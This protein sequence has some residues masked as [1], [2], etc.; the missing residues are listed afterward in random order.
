MKVCL[1]SHA[2]P[3]SIGGIETVS[4]LL[5]DYLHS[6]GVGV[7]VVTET[8]A[9]NERAAPAY[10]VVRRPGSTALRPLAAAHDLMHCNGMS[11][12]GTL[13]AF[14]GGVPLVVTHQSYN[15]AAPHSF[16]ELRKMLVN[17]GPRRIPHAVASALGVHLADLNVCISR[18]L[19]TC[20][21]P[22]RSLVLYNPIS[23]I[24][25]PLP[26]TERRNNFAFVGRLVAD[27]GCDVLLIALAECARRGYRYGVEVYGDGPERE[28]LL[29]LA[30]QCGVSEKARFCGSV[31]GID[32]VRAY[33]RSLAVVV[34]SVWQEPLGIVALE[35]MA[36]GRAV[37]ASASG[38]LEEVVQGVGMLFPVGNSQ[39]L[40]D[41]MI[42]LAE[43]SGLRQA[44]ERTGAQ[45]ARK[46]S[47][48]VMG[49]MYLEL[50]REVL[51]Q[52]RK[53]GEMHK[54]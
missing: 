16:R 43:N 15:A 3:P 27:K 51:D 38:G 20:L 45:V 17:E 2:F 33:N 36:C 53:H 40:A 4:E 12:R 28:N 32:L 5:A 34:P 30:K 44:A 10:R 50:Y 31:R 23:P 47:I 18:F 41:C 42:R 1:Y 29:A 54:N 9:N 7:T 8:P 24:F 11:V 19:H 26:E 49:K 52:K 46:F 13:A 21:H 39:A 6:R 35:A 14:L 48:E 37:I 25:Q 22:P